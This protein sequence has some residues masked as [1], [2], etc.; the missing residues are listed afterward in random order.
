MGLKPVISFSTLTRKINNEKVL[1][2][3]FTCSDRIDL[4]FTFPSIELPTE[5]DEQ[6]QWLFSN[7]TPTFYY[8]LSR[9]KR[10]E[11]RNNC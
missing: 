10:F 5:I 3:S 1:H 6:L 7:T 11:L 4:T 8:F 9:S 2:H